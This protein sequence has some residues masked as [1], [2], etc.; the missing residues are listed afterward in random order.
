MPIHHD[1]L[2][3]DQAKIFGQSFIAEILVCCLVLAGIVDVGFPAVVSRL[4]NE[5]FL[6]HLVTSETV[7]T[8]LMFP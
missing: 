4:T 8:V 2:R 1:H 6:G 3:V 5:W 7:Q